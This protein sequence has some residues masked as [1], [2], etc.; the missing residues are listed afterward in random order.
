MFQTLLSFLTPL[1]TVL[2]SAAYVLCCASARQNVKKTLDI[3][4]T[5]VNGVL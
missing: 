5:S 1:C 3:L 4:E 2:I